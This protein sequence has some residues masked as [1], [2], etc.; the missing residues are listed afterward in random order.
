M[1]RSGDTCGHGVRHDMARLA[2]RPHRKG[3][4]PR[5]E[6]GRDQVPEVGSVVIAAENVWRVHLGPGQLPIDEEVDLGDDC[7]GGMRCRNPM[8]SQGNGMLPVQRRSH[9][10]QR[11][12]ARGGR[13]R[14]AR[15]RR[16]KNHRQ[17]TPPP[18]SMSAEQSGPG[19]PRT[20][21]PMTSR[22]APQRHW[23]DPRPL[24]PWRGKIRLTGSA[25]LSILLPQQLPVAERLLSLL[26]R[27]RAVEAASIATPTIPMP[28][29]GRDLSI[30]PR[31]HGVLPIC[32]LRIPPSSQALCS[33]LSGPCHL[34]FDRGPK[35]SAHG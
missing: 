33:R 1:W 30:G 20:S 18:A 23:F 17:P 9:L 16:T 4:T 31:F 13:A 5:R 28:A 14:L 34:S 32:H 25:R 10:L 12:G 8:G 11:V 21:R 7:S 19:R 15:R 6:P 26:P 22:L 29:A 27:D 35:G 3:M 2:D 24:A